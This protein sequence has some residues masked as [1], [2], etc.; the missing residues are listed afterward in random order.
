LITH[1]ILRIWPCRTITWSLDWKIIE[2]WP[3]F[4]R[5]KGHC[6][7]GDLF[8]RTTF[9]I[10]FWVACKSY[11]NRLRSVVSFVGEYV[12]QIPSFFAVACYIP[13][14]AK[15]VKAHPRTVKTSTEGDHQAKTEEHG[16]VLISL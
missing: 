15:D 6:C 9:W 12:E 1:P 2:R 14:R 4:V 11:S 13:G 3:F 10:F 8:G 7:R 5:R 16:I